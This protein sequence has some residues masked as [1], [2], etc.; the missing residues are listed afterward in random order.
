MQSDREKDGPKYFHC[1]VML[2]GPTETSGHLFCHCVAAT[3]RKEGAIA[4][5]DLFVQRNLCCHSLRKLK[6][7][8]KYRAVSYERRILDIMIGTDQKPVV[9]I[10]F[11]G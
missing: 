6:Q 4:L 11:D 1:E 5:W 8:G 7:S 10:A 9:P 2:K 3:F